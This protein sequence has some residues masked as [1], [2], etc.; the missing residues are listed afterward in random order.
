MRSA[1]TQ[2]P[3][4]RW[5]V[6]ASPLILLA[7]VDRIHLLSELPDALTIPSPV[8]EELRAGPEEDPARR[9]LLHEGSAYVR[10]VAAVVPEVAAWDVGRGE[11]AVLSWAYRDKS[12][13]AVID[14]LA[15]RQC[16]RALDIACTGTIGVVLAA[17]HN[18]VIPEVAPVLD[19]LISAGL[20]ISTDVMIQ[21]RRLAD[22]F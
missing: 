17:K 10:P 6:D 7:K 3:M 16:A 9:W 11:S 14:D 4:R 2:A 18:R 20:R 15:A 8:A 12:W 13:L 5:V 21:A 1:K 19:A 22:E